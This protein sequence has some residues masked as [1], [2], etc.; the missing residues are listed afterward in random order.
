MFLAEVVNLKRKRDIFGIPK[1]NFDNRW[2]EI[3]YNK[4]KNFYF[5]D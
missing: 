4:F 5:I 3:N 1:L 2:N